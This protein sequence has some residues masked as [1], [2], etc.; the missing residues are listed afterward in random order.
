MSEL[1]N[2]DASGPGDLD[3]ALDADVPDRHVVQQRPVLLDRVGVV[4]RAGTCGCRCRRRCSRRPASSR[5]TASAGTTGRNRGWTRRS[6]GARSR[7][8]T[9]RGDLLAG[10]RDGQPRDFYCLSRSIRRTSDRQATPSDPAASPSSTSA[11]PVVQ[12]TT[13]S[14]EMVVPWATTWSASPSSSDRIR[15]AAPAGSGA[16]E[17]PG[18]D[19]RPDRPLEQALPLEVEPARRRL[20]RRPAGRL[21]PGV[22]PEL[23]RPVLVGRRV[24]PEED[25]QRLDRVVGLPHQPRGQLEVL[26]R[27]LLERRRQHVV[28]RVE[29]VV[30]QPARGAHHGRHVAHGRGGQGP[31]T[32]ATSSAAATIASRRW[33]GGMRVLVMTRSVGRYCASVQHGISCPDH[34]HAPPRHEGQHGMIRTTPFHE[35]TAALNETQL[36][37]HWSGTLAADRYQMSDK[38]EYFAV[39]NAAGRLRL[40]P[41]LQ[42]PHR[43]QGRRGV[44]RRDPGPRHPGLPAG[45]RPL[46]VLAG[47]RRLR[48]RGRGHPPHG[49]GRVPPDLGRAQLRLLR[50]P[51]RPDGGHDRGGQRGHRHA[52]AAGPAL[53]RPARPPR[54]ADARHPLLR[55][56]E[57][58]DRRR[59]A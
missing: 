20:E 56:R 12:R 50:G 51:H 16:R 3:D 4:A 32:T 7:G 2:A 54:P 17:R 44:P 59:G 37:S 52:R 23:E 45:P 55:G 22:E 35:R 39:R 13:S 27:D 31:S 36:W 46:H 18:R 49:P 42:V 15:H 5:R 57:G 26:A 30:D 53:A 40:E 34:R 33:S 1:V 41:A 29:V 48:H 14:R 28:H 58:R 47:R 24:G 25:P 8:W 6:W 19:A 38:F 10:S 9:S 43:R 11:A 21:R